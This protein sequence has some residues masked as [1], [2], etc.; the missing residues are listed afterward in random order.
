[1]SAEHG[2]HPPELEPGNPYYKVLTLISPEAAQLRGIPAE[3]PVFVS[4][5]TNHK[6]LCPHCHI[7]FT[8]IV[9]Q[10]G[11]EVRSQHNHDDRGGI[12]YYAPSDDEVTNMSL[13]EITGWLAEIEPLGNTYVG[14]DH[15]RSDSVRVNKIRAFC[16]AKTSSAYHEVSS[17]I[18]IPNRTSKK[19]KPQCE[20]H[21]I[22]PSITMKPNIWRF[23]INSSGEVGFFPPQFSFDTMATQPQSHDIMV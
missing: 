1:M 12:Y 18:L 10:T 20:A 14:A 2:I 7:E 23:E 17:G 15:L 21:D 11:Y 5:F 3:S 6:G 4:P 22:D 9:Y 8:P 19:L 16:P 13:G